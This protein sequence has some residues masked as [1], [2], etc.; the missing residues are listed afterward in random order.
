VFCTTCFGGSIPIQ[1][2]EN[3]FETGQQS[4]LWLNLHDKKEYVFHALKYSSQ[5]VNQIVGC[6]ERSLTS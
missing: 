4:M 3:E 5:N 2:G 6:V 1:A